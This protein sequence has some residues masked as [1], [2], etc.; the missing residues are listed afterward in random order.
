MY[1]QFVYFYH[2]VAATSTVGEIS[3][4]P[5]SGNFNDICCIQY[6]VNTHILPT[7]YCKIVAVAVY[8]LYGIMKFTLTES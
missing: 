5:T 6:T 7:T 2:T 8:M 3:N 1:D 4:V